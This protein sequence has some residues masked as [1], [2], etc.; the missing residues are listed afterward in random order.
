MKNKL[1]VLVLLILV[2]ANI[3]YAQPTIQA[4][5]IVFSN[6]TTSQ[7][8]IS[9]TRG[10]DGDAVAVFVLAGSAGLAVP[11]DNTTYT[12]NTIFT[13]GDQIGAT[14]WFCVFNGAGTTVTVTGLTAN[15][16]YRAM[17]LEYDG[18]AGAELYLQGAAAD[19]PLNK[20]TLPAAP[21]LT[22]PAQYAVG[23]SVLPTLSWTGAGDVTA[24]EMEISLTSGGAAIAISPAYASP[25]TS[26]TFTYFTTASTV[27]ANGTTYYW[28]VRQTTPAGT[29][30]WSSV[31]EFVT[32]G[33]AVPTLSPITPGATSAYIGWY[34]VP[35]SSGLKYDLLRST[36]SNMTGYTT[37]TAGLTNTYYTLPLVQGTSYYVQVRATNSDGTVVISY[38]TVSSIITPATPPMPIPSYPTSP[39]SDGDIYA[40]PPTLFWYIDGNEPTLTYEIEVVLNADPFLYTNGTAIGVPTITSTKTFKT[41]SS[42]LTAG[43]TYKW[44]VRSISGT[45]KSVWSTATPTFT[46]YTTTAS[47]GI[48][49]TPSWPVGNPTIYQN[50]PTLYWYL[51]SDKTG[52]YYQVQYSE[53]ADTTGAGLFSHGSAV[54]LPPGAAD[55]SSSLFKQLSATLTPAQKYYWRVRSGTSTAGANSSPWSAIGSGS[56]EASFTIASTA[57]GGAATPIPSWPVGGAIMDGTM[58]AITLSWTAASTVALDFKVKM[59]TSSSVNGSGELNHGSAVETLGWVATT[60]SAN[61]AAVFGASLTAGATYYWQVKSRLTGTPAVVSAWSMVAS[62]S[63]AAGASSVVPLIVSPNYLQPLKSTAAVLSWNIPVQSESHL[64][65]DLQYSKNSNFSNAVTVPNLNSPSTLVSGLEPNSTYYWR[66]LSKT[67]KGSISSYSTTG[68]FKTTGTTAVGENEVIPTDYELA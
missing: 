38:S 21:S 50:P 43:E 25:A 40:N 33:A 1:T 62:F 6:V 49:P 36:S 67:D 31:R 59:A 65:Y 52:L 3:N 66:V 23:V 54:L 27:L 18:G 32:V 61:A 35:Y 44:Q 46:M 4:N 53:T 24:F 56:T 22:A 51:G 14:G 47:D 29:S 8:D 9:W 68:T 11:V 37:V 5:S 2:L 16:A 64:K 34:P 19:N 15:T 10:G 57:S 41:L 28:R 13:S 17:V 12:A 58:S 63:T 48:R 45:G 26:H 20:S 7:M 60:T 39:G 30:A 55:W 42:S